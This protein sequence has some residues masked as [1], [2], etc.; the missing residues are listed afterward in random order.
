MDYED[1]FGYQQPTNQRNNPKI[2]TKNNGVSI[3]KNKNTVIEDYPS[4]NSNFNLPSKEDIPIREINRSNKVD[5]Q[6]YD[7]SQFMECRAGCGR[8]FNPDSLAKH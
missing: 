4:Y 7:P 8:K 1:N 3:P 2:S 6:E 5:I